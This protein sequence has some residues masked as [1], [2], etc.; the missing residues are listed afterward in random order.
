M[1][2]ALLSS[3]DSLDRFRVPMWA[4]QGKRQ[5]E[6]SGN[7]EDRTMTQGGE[8]RKVGGS[9]RQV[10]ARC[11]HADESKTVVR[12]AKEMGTETRRCWDM[13]AESRW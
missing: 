4:K 3:I 11:M 9:C 12:A 1:F 13:P 8:A 6:S 5:A 10:V 7:L 2:R